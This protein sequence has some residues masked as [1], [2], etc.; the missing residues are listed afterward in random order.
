MGFCYQSDARL[1][2]SFTKTNF[3]SNS[4]G[5]VTEQTNAISHTS[6]TDWKRNVCRR[7]FLQS[8]FRFVRSLNFFFERIFFLSLENIQSQGIRFRLYT[9]ERFKRERLLA[10]AMVMFG[11]VNLDEDMC[12]IIP[13]ER[14][15]VTQNRFWWFFIDV[16]SFGFFSRTT[17]PIK[18]EDKVE[19]RVTHSWNQR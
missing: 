17:I 10:E 3:T 15:H 2:S 6:Q 1:T 19:H 8:Y 12:K 11:A 5:D 14:A 13:L 4:F 16:F 18:A 7:I 9:N